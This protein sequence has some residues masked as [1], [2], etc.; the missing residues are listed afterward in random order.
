[1]NGKYATLKDVAKLAGTTA[2]TVS[3][4]LNDSKE[5]YIS[6]EMRR[7]VLEAAKDLNYVKCSV[8][9]SLKGEKRKIIAVLVPQF[10][11]Q[12]FTRIILAIENVADQFDYVLTIYNTFDDPKREKVI[13]N[14]M[15][16]HR[17]D[18]YI[19]IPTYEGVKNTE[20]LR[21][22][23]IPMVVMDRPLEGIDDFIWVTTNNY[24][25]GYKGAH[26]LALK[27]HRNIAFIGWNSRINDLDSR[28]NGFWDALAASGITSEEAIVIDGE[29]SEEDGYKMT[30]NLLK[31]RPD[32]TAIFYGYNVQAQG[33]VRY[34]MKENIEIGKDISVMLIGS[35]EW[36][37]TGYNNFTHIEQDEYNL[38]KSAATILFSIIN[39]ENQENIQNIIQ[40]C[41]LYE[42]NSVYDITKTKKERML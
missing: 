31:T 7:R 11:N 21:K 14:R 39:G 40:D 24:Q 38:G 20:Q 26:Y 42:G 15:A 9:S 29:F 30:K 1:M 28:K 18:G 3:Y 2:S 12:F 4:V 8:A 13:I 41:S 16:Q 25:C 37:V 36:A 19:I 32:I 34:L 10:S 27:G 23:G 17:M 22:I 35:P 6:D 5:R 33:G